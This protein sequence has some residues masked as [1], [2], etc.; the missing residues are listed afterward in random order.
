MSICDT[1][2]VANL[3]LFHLSGHS[4]LLTQHSYLL[5]AMKIVVTVKIAHT[6]NGI[7][8][9]HMHICVKLNRSCWCAIAMLTLCLH[10][11]AS[12]VCATY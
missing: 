6:V 11:L 8:G 3:M 1:T 4:P 9:V 2:A 10:R 7:I 5:Y 12:S